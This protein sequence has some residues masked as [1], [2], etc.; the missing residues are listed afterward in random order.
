[1]AYDNHPEAADRL[2]GERPVS[3]LRIAVVGGFDRQ[4][5]L[6]HDMAA[7]SGHSVEFHTGNV[8]G[9]GA[10]E[11]RAVI[12]RS[13]LVVIVTDHNS[14]GGVQ[15]AKRLVRQLDRSSVVVSRCGV[16]RFGALLDAIS[17]RARHAR[18]Y[19]P[20]AARA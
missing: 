9:R 3:G 10:G 13:D 4:A 5:P 2:D 7:R 11:L 1:M 6:L 14:H 17:A 20:M 19:E 16:A 15:A 8:R 18:R 12:A